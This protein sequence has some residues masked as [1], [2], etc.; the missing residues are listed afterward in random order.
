MCLTFNGTNGYICRTYFLLH[1]YHISQDIFYLSTIHCLWSTAAFPNK[2]FK[3]CNCVILNKSEQV[4]NGKIYRPL[5]FSISNWNCSWL[6]F[7]TPK[8]HIIFIFCSLNFLAVPAILNVIDFRD[9][10]PGTSEGSQEWEVSVLPCRKVSLISLPPCF[11]LQK[12]TNKAAD[13][14]WTCSSKIQSA[15]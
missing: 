10:S 4:L 1:M 14:E 7:S 8:P 3:N 11:Q 9:A 13:T 5:F 12:P 2:C 15:K 6:F